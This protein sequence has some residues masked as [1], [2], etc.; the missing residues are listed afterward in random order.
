[1]T[2]RKNKGLEW[3]IQDNLRS[4]AFEFR[5]YGM[6][7]KFQTRIDRTKEL[8]DIKGK[9]DNMFKDLEV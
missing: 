6:N 7:S 9:M 2:L 5:M 1:M 3:R 4:A 8:I